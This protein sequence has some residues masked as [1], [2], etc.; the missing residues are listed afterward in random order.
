MLISGKPI[1]PKEAM[2][3]KANSIPPEVFDAFNEL[4]EARS[5]PTAPIRVYITQNEVVEIII[6]KI[7]LNAPH[8]AGGQSA[9]EAVRAK[10]FSEHWLDVEDAYRKAGWTVRYD[11]PGY[12]ESYDAN[13][14]FSVRK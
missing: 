13:F 7:L 2:T 5:G 4:L 6:R 12:N 10:I 9:A 3:S 8:D 11:K 1:T 14:T